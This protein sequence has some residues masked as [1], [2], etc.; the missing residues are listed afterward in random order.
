MNRMCKHFLS[1]ADFSTEHY[2]KITFS[3]DLDIL[4][5]IFHLTIDCNDIVIFINSPHLADELICLLTAETFLIQGNLNTVIVASTVLPFLTRKVNCADDPVAAANWDR[6]C[7]D[8]DAVLACQ[9]DVL[10]FLVD[11]TSGLHGTV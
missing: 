9:L 3:N 7:L 10:I 1:G 4:F 5:C 6:K 2:G 11:G 8:C